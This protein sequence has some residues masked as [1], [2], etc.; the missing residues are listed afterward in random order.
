M[1]IDWLNQN[2]GAVQALAAAGTLFLTL[3]LVGAT[4]WYA[5]SAKDQTSELRLART[6]AVA[7]YVRV[8]DAEVE[9]RNFPGPSTPGGYAKGDDYRCCGSTSKTWAVA[10]LSVFS[11]AHEGC[12]PVSCWR[13]RQLRPT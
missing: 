2:A 8:A 13:I 4:L 11:F 5:K 9:E 7:P 6:A 3:V 12:R 10:Q 1:S